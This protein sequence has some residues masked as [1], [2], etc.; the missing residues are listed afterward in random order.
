[1]YICGPVFNVSGKRAN[2]FLYV[3]WKQSLRLVLNKAKG[4]HFISDL[5]K[6]FSSH[7]D[8][9]KNSLLKNGPPL[10]NDINMA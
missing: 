5:K 1:M 7:K 2:L 3:D 10:A 6:Y 4:K 9:E 8:K